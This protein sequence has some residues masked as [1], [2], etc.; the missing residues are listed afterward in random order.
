MSRHRLDE[1][2][3]TRHSVIVQKSHDIYWS[4]R[5]LLGNKL[6]TESG[7]LAGAQPRLKSWGGPWFGS[8]HRGAWAP[9]QA[10]G[11][12]GCWVWEGVAPSRCEGPGVSPPKIYE[13][14]DGKSCILVTTCCGISCFL[15]TTAKKFGDQYIVGPQPKSWGT[16]LPRSLR[17]LRLCQLADKENVLTLLI[18]FLTTRKRRGI[19]V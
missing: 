15:K 3:A 18:S 12:A 1:Q 8:Q 16:S 6:I 10:K 7:Q 9:R 4:T 13:S 11:R 2:T 19:S 5:F 14:S 17:L